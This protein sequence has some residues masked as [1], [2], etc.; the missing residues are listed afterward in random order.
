[1]GHTGDGPKNSSNDPGPHWDAEEKLGVGFHVPE[2]TKTQIS[3]FHLILDTSRAQYVLDMIEWVTSRIIKNEF[4][5]FRC[6]G[7]NQYNHI[8][9][10]L[11]QHIDDCP[12]KKAQGLKEVLK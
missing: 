10:V 6:L 9:A 12:V 2:L 7:C 1:M 11:I 8:D 5:T 3:L 4:G